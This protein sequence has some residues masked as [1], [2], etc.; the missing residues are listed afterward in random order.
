VPEPLPEPFRCD[1]EPVHGWI[2]VRPHGELDL[3]SADQLDG[4]LR[5]LRET[6]FD[7]I[8]LDLSSLTFMDSTG[9]RIVLAWDDVARRDGMHLRLVPGPP[10]VQRVFEVT[11]VVDRLPFDVQGSAEA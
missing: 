5:E 9:L 1:V 10:A 7:Q 2:R 11:G 8:E 4:K 3:A 6:G